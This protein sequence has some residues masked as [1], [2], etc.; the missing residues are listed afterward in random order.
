MND[1]FAW[2]FDIC[3]THDAFKETTHLNFFKN[4]NYV[5]VSFYLVV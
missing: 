2:S 3:D 5:L 4:K 1:Q